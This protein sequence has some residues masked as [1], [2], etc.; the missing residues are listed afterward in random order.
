MTNRRAF[1]A[2]L[3]VLPA[4][5]AAGLRK[6]P[7]LERQ[8]FCFN[9]LRMTGPSKWLPQGA[10]IDG[11][12]PPEHLC[13][14]CVEAVAYCSSCGRLLAN[15][16]GTLRISSAS[17]PIIYSAWPKL[18]VT[19]LDLRSYQYRL[20]MRPVARDLIVAD[21]S[22]CTSFRELNDSYLRR[23][24]YAFSIPPSQIL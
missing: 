22:K 19:G 24:C 9:C 12:H 6:R 17:E 8:R 15:N 2:T 20:G 3:M 23:V 10:G 21:C 7:S 14:D 13:D 11:T 1:L 16:E 18:P 5:A 4:T